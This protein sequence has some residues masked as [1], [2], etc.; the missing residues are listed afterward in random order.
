MYN[1]IQTLSSEN[2]LDFN[3][4]SEI[5]VYPTRVKLLVLNTVLGEAAA[6]MAI[7]RIQTEISLLTSQY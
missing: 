7:N 6:G 5:D 2:L 1:Q 4:G 3:K